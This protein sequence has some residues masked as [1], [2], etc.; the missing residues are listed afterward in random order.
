[1]QAYTV[2]RAP[3]GVMPD[4][5]R[6][7]MFTLRHASGMEVRAINYGAIITSIRVPDRAGRFAD[8][9]NGHD[10]LDGYLTRSRFF[11]AVV[12]RY[13]NRIAK[14]RFTL[15]GQ[16]IPAGRQQRPESPSWRPEGLRQGRVERARRDEGGQRRR[17]LRADE[18]R[19]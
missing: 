19:R 11:G 16:G 15:D 14:G 2:E 12:G 9:V 4:G 18:S 17:D 10:A 8:V 6:V 1:M 13:G 5:A 3:F 7:E